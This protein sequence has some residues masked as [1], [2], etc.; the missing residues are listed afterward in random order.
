ME[1]CFACF[2][3]P[4]WASVTIGVFL[5]QTCAGVH[6]SLASQSRVK[7]VRLDNWDRDQVEV[8]IHIALFAGQLRESELATYTLHAV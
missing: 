4:D 8:V 6:R 7:S 3:D 1:F 2:S 5:C